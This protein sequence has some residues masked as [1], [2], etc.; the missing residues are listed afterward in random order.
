MGRTTKVPPIKEALKQIN[1]G[2]QNTK[3][4]E[5]LEINNADQNSIHFVDGDVILPS[6]L[7]LPRTTSG[8]SI[9][10][11]FYRSGN[12][13]WE[14]KGMP[15]EESN[16]HMMRNVAAEQKYIPRGV[17]SC[18]EYTLDMHLQS[19]TVIVKKG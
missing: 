1:Q 9:F 11:A 19:T 14:G 16:N 7:M 17:F 12:A 5:V 10:A 3:T 8:R 13:A 6:A 18:M 15:S 2:W 4:G